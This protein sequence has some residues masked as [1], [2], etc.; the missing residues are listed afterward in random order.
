MRSETTKF[1]TPRQRLRSLHRIDQ[2]DA[3][4]MLTR[5]YLQQLD[6]AYLYPPDIRHLLEAAGFSGVRISSDFD[7]RPFDRDTDELVIEALRAG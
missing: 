1:D 6:L 2:F 5:T 4:G 3:S 7:G